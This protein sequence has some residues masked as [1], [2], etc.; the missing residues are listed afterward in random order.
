MDFTS[1][2][3]GELMEFIQRKTLIPWWFHGIRG[4][5]P[6]GDLPWSPK[7]VDLISR[8]GKEFVNDPSSC[9]LRVALVPWWIWAPIPDVLYDSRP[10]LRGLLSWKISHT[11][12]FF[13]QN[14]RDIGHV[15]AKMAAP[16][17]WA[18]ERDG[19]SHNIFTFHGFPPIKCEVFHIE[20]QGGSQAI[21]LF[22]HISI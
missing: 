10:E 1:K 11:T 22:E 19:I 17:L 14:H 4:L 6:G 5:L 2:F 13:N 3:A 12:H 18:L 21:I 16:K 20:F 8:G 7:W 15:L 9:L